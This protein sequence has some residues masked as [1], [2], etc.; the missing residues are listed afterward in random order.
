MLASHSL[1]TR[2]GS[3][4][5]GPEAELQCILESHLSTVYQHHDLQD[6]LWSGGS[7][8]VGAGSPDLIIASCRKEISRYDD[9]QTVSHIILGYLRSV[10]RAKT[11]T[12]SNRVGL[13]S[14]SLETVLECLESNNILFVEGETVNLDPAW[15]DILRDV[16]AIEVKVSDWRKAISQA[17]R[18]KVLAHRSYIALPTTLARRVSEETI[19]RTHG[20]GVIAI[21]EDGVNIVRRSR[22]S[23][24]K[25]W[26]YYYALAH[27]AAQAL[28]RQKHGVPSTN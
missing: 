25:V 11:S 16:V 1:T 22:Q 5:P 19:L 28:D 23:L 9:V 7:V 27:R 24:P 26:A 3:L 2:Y 14:R 21:S 17:V 6:V 8:P 12:I 18:N 13:S 4:R 15:R 10:G 20:I